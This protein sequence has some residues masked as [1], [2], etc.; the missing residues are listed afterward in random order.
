ML[1]FPASSLRTALAL[2]GVT[3]LAAALSAET[4]VSAPV[5]EY[6][7]SD[8][9]SEMFPKFKLAVDAKN[10][11]AALAVID[12]YQ[13]KVAP[14][15]YDFAL[16][17]Q[18]RSSILLQKGDFAAAMQPMEQALALSD[19]KTPTYFDERATREFLYL[20]TSLYLQEAV[21][22]KAPALASNYFEK[23]DKS[24]GR[25]LKLSP[26]TTADAQLV[27]SQ[28]LYTWA[29]QNPAKPDP[30]LLKRA[31]EQIETG[32]HL[33]T[34]PHDTFYVLKMVCLQQL[35]RKAETAE[36]LELMVKRK[37]DSSTYWQ[38]LAGLYLG[39]DQPLRAIL[40][41]ER[42][43]ANGSLN[44]PKENFNLIG[45]YYNIGQY[46]HVTDMLETGLKNGQIQNELKN[47]ELLALCYQQLQQPLKGIEALKHASL[48]YP[49]SGQLE[50][51]IAQAYYSLDKPED[52]IRH[53]KTAVA[54]G[55][56][57]KPHQVYLF[58]A[59]LAFELKQF[60]DVLDAVKKAAAIPEGAND[61][62][63]KNMT[64]A[65][66]DILKNREAK[67]SKM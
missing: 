55:G 15:S 56:L 5:R 17:L 44:T 39:I 23:G 12:A 42:A 48:S 25:W 34:R 67:K 37:P 61:P 7:P 16:L 40:A 33:A 26:K 47:W 19:S 63:V 41:L 32:L 62:Q 65:I 30:E 31:L 59:Y 28:L 22:S 8:A 6:S 64:K 18:Y 20:L 38:Q 13:A 1:P 29:V 2:V 24:F 51:M 3:L 66:E 52:A 21:Q 53:L 60:D 10:Y 50:Y 58:L 35:N 14:A 45:I 11:D 49:K 46:E 27:Y 36:V 54:K 57:A 4:P 9:V 43:Q